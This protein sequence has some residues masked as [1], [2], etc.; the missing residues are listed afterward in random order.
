MNYSA[1]RQ[2]VLFFSVAI[3]AGYLMAGGKWEKAGELTKGGNVSVGKEI[4]SVK[5]VS[6]DDIA[7]INTL[8]VKVDN[9]W[10]IIGERITINKGGNKEFGCI[11]AKV[12]E[13]GMSLETRGK[14]EVW[15][16]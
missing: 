16:K 12:S 7:T 6:I 2:L 4:S 13:I 1:V 10:Q 8:M 15:V 11:K 5:I 9:K 3:F 14:V